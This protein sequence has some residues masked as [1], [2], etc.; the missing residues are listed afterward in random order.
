MVDTKTDAFILFNEHETLVESIVGELQ[1]SGVST[2]FW[3]SD[4]PIGEAWEGLEAQ[5]LRDAYNVCVFLGSSGWGPTHL[6][7]TQEAQ[8]LQKRIIPVLI[9]D[10]PDQAFEEADGLFRTRRYLDL[11]TPDPVSIRR[12]ADAIRRREP[13]QVGQFDRIVGVLVDGNE[14]ERAGVLRQIVISTSLDRPALAARLRTEIR[15]RFGPKSESQFASAIRDPKKISSIRSWMLSSLIWAH[16]EGPESRQIIL[17]HLGPDLEPDRNVRYWTLA[18]LYQ[19][20][21]SYLNEALKVGLSDPRPRSRSCAR[22]HRPLGSSA[23]R[24]VPKSTGLV[25]VRDGVA[26]PPPPAHCPDP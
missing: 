21:S 8:R 5:Q 17:D 1:S 9:G 16:A 3:R 18:G 15:D 2:Y 6:K 23:H 11:R 22:D 10:P 25:R 13:S 4:V 24:T 26:G 7:I 19:S 20:K 14:E 12:L